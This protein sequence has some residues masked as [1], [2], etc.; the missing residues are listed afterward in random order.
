MTFDQRSVLR[1]KVIIEIVRGSPRENLQT[2]IPGRL[3]QAF[4]VCLIASGS[5][6]SSTLLLVS[7]DLLLVEGRLVHPVV[8]ATICG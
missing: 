8:L 3:C 6:A 5:D 2:H 7:M 1:A 4:R